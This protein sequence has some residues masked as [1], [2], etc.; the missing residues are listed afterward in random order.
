MCA[1]K[2]VNIVEVS[3]AWYQ[4]AIV[5]HRYDDCS[6]LQEGVGLAIEPCGFNIYNDGQ[7]ATESMGNR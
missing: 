6:E 7:V 4:Q 1:W 2:G 3:F 5:V